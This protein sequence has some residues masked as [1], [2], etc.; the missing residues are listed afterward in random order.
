MSFKSLFDYFKLCITSKYC[1][2]SG[3]ARRAE[4]WGFMLFYFIGSVLVTVLSFFLFSGVDA[5]VDFPEATFLQAQIQA[6][7]G[8]R[9]LKGVYN[10]VL[11]LPILGVSVRRLHDTGR[12]S[13]WITLPLI[14]FIVFI[15]S[16]IFAIF[17]MLVWLFDISAIVF[18][19]SG[20]VLLVFFCL[21]SQPGHNQYGP[22]PKDE[23]LMPFDH[24]SSMDYIKQSDNTY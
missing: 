3:R 19:L 10:L 14:S 7:S 23:D 6:L 4:F 15:S 18:M 17:G 16:I 13:L 1:S 24:S 22:N 11:L 12:S 5:S 2:F 8:M 21:D 20:I 9:A